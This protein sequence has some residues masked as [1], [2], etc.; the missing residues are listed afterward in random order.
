MNTAQLGD[1]IYGVGAASDAFFH[2]S[3]AQLGPSQ[4]ARLAAVLPNPDRLHVDR[5]S[6]YVMERSRWIEQ[7]MNQLSGP[8]YLESAQPPRDTTRARR[9]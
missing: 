6:A 9:R 4:A 7:Q 2:A 8:A 5:P 1:G 3:P